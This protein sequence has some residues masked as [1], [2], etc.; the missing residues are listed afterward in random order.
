MLVFMQQIGHEHRISVLTINV[1]GV[2]TQPFINN[3]VKEPMTELTTQNLKEMII[4]MGTMQEWI[5]DI[6]DGIEP[7]DFALSYPMVRRVWEL[8]RFWDDA[9]AEGKGGPN[10][11]P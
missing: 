3:S 1:G 7:S 10:D 2:C 8:K 4:A 5:S 11:C 6:L 9:H